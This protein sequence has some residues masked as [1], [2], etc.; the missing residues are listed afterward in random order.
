MFKHL[1][2]F[3]HIIRYHRGNLGSGQQNLGRRQSI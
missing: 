3:L 2:A 1:R